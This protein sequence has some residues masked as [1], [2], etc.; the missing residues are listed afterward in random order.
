LRYGREWMYRIAELGEKFL[1]WLRYED[2][3][4]IKEA[5]EWLL[6]FANNVSYE[7]IVRNPE[8]WLKTVI[9]MMLNLNL[10]ILV[11]EKHFIRWRSDIY[12][13]CCWRKYVI[14]VKVDW[15]KKELL[16]QMRGYKEEA[17]VVIGINWKRKKNV[18]E[19]M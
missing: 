8:W 7:W 3:N 6:E 12:V 11:T 18:V 9:V 19:V 16:K 14:E 15:T 10:D 13:E 4:K 1:E 17:D 5:I 2:K